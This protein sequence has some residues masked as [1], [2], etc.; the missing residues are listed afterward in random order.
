MNIDL[1]SLLVLLGALQALFFGIFLLFTRTENPFQN[2]ML[3]GLMFILSYNGFETLNWSSGLYPG[4]WFFDAFGFVLIFGFGPCLYLYVRSFRKEGKPAAPWKH[5]IMIWLALAIKLGLLICWKL[6][7]LGYAYPHAVVW[8]YQV[9]DRVAE[10]LSVAWACVYFL[11][12]L[13]EWLQQRK[14]GGLMP[15]EDRWLK[16]L[17]VVMG[18][19]H[20]VWLITVAVPYI[21]NVTGAQQYSVIEVMLVVFIYWI[22]FAGYH[23]TR[24]IYAARQQQARSY[25]DQ[26]EDTEI[27]RCAEALHRA[28]AAERLYLDPEMTASVLAERIGVPVKTLSAVLNRQMGK[29][30]N[31]YINSWR[32]EAV[33]DRMK[34][35]ACKHL[36]LSGIAFECGFNSQPTFQRAFRAVTGCSPREF[37]RQQGGE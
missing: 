4:I 31:E 18:V 22:G 32:V 26:L 6:D 21:W 16:I 33:K 12:A 20:C 8:V 34:D 10:R 27:A 35:P 29:G 28:M 17:M 11:L 7:Q 2:R 37:L 15:E 23:R 36:T 9:F 25:F 5:F 13:R 3:A 14:G 1:F 24:V 30:F 19:F